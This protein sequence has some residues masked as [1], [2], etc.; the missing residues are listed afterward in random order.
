MFEESRNFYV[1]I[2][3]EQRNHYGEH[4]CGDVFRSKRIMTENR[5]VAVLSDGM[6]H[7]VKANVMATFTAAFAVNFTEEHKDFEKIAD[8]IMNTLPVCAERKMSYSTFTIVDIDQTGIVKIMSYSN[9]EI[10]VYNGKKSMNLEWEDIE[11]TTTKNKGK[12]LRATEFEPKKGDRIIFCSD[13]VSQAGLGS[14]EYPFGWGME[15]CDDYVVRLISKTSDISA[16][17]LSS[18]VVA[19][20]FKRDNYHAKDDISCATVYFRDPRKCL[21]CTGPPFNPENDS[22]YAEI[23]ADFVGKKIICGGTSSEIIARELKLKIYDKLEG[24]FDPGMPPQFELDGFDLVTEGIL[25]LTRIYDLLKQYHNLNFRLCKG[26]ADTIVSTLLNSDEICFLVGT[27]INTTNQD[28]S[29][30]N[31]ELE[32]RRT[33]VNRIARILDEVFLKDVKIIYL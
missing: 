9:P 7:G 25:T 20:A 14:E 19:Q 2:A 22:E 15:N 16:A 5:I 27:G 32:V 26:S 13:G 3:C 6:G 31:I 24:D 4:I 23:A 21:I 18:L 11:M 29:L 10:L 30:L 33:V 17:Q 8:I 12:M 1:D 28:P